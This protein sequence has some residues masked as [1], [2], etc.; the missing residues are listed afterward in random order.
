MLFPTGATD[1][2][3][4]QNSKNTSFE[5]CRTPAASHWFWLFA[6]HHFNITSA[7]MI[8][9]TFSKGLPLVSTSPPLPNKPDSIFLYVLF[10]RPIHCFSPLSLHLTWEQRGK[11]TFQGVFTKCEAQQLVPQS[12][13]W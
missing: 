10:S 7:A 11:V 13:C 1:P 8:Q 5:D 3:I 2:W 6:R 9:A 12:T 4:I